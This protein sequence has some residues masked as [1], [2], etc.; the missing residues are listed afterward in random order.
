MLVLISRIQLEINESNFIDFRFFLFFKIIQPFRLVS[1]KY[2][3]LVLNKFVYL[4]KA[5]V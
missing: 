4:Q 2:F 3:K 1:N 5:V